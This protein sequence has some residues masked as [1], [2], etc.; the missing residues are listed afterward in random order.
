MGCE[1]DV[2]IETPPPPVYDFTQTKIELKRMLNDLEPESAEARADYDAVVATIDAITTPDNL[3]AARSAVQSFFDEYDFRI[4][5]LNSGRDAGGYAWEFPELRAADSIT[6]AQSASRISGGVVTGD[7]VTFEGARV[8]YRGYDDVTGEDF[9]W[10]VLGVLN[11]ESNYTPERRF[12]GLIVGNG[13]VRKHAGDYQPAGAGFSIDERF[14][15]FQ[16]PVSV[17]EMVEWIIADAETRGYDISEIR[18]LSIISMPD[19]GVG[20]YATPCKGEVV[21]HEGYVGRP[22]LHSEYM[23]GLSTMYHEIGH[24]YFSYRHP[25]FDPEGCDSGLNAPFCD[26]ISEG[27]D[28]HQDIMGY[29]SINY[30]NWDLAVERWLEGTGHNTYNC[31][32]GKRNVIIN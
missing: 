18:E 26:N 3:S 13:H 10:G 6:A 9:G 11:F 31:E 5:L 12:Y 25:L 2:I 29:G 8:H 23:S 19:I 21:V 28:N 27:Y 24:S 30:E 14:S 16:N 7:F 15:I 17:E 1:K 32:T 22:L 4:G 20:G